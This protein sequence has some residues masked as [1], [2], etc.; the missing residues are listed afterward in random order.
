[1]KTSAL[2]LTNVNLLVNLHNHFDLPVPESVYLLFK[3][4]FINSV[5]QLLVVWKEDPS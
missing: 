3:K 2:I 5:R 4:R 1:M